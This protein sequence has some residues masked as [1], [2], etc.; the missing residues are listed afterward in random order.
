MLTHRA[1]NT[2]TDNKRVISRRS[3]G[4]F[5]RNYADLRADSRLLTALA[6]KHP[7]V[8]YGTH[9]HS[10]GRWDP[11]MVS[12][13]RRE[14]SSCDSL[15]RLFPASA[16]SI[17]VF[18]DPWQTEREKGRKRRDSSARSLRRGSILPSG[19]CSINRE[20]LMNNEFSCARLFILANDTNNRF[21]WCSRCS[22]R[23]L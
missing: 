17:R 3:A 15:P 2:F 11:Q 21:L 8:I 12:R 6:N 10:F 19:K 7:H 20:I 4:A 1:N 9:S 22:R 18:W 13:E 5:T 16:I 14:S 23:S